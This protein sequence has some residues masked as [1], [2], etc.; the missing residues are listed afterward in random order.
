MEETKVFTKTLNIAGAVILCAA[1]GIASGNG[2]MPSKFMIRVENTTKPDAFTASNGLKWSLAFS[3][4]VAVIHTDKAPIF[5]SGKKDRGK[6]LEAQSEDGDPS[7]LAKSLEG[8]Q[9]I[10]SVVVFNTPAGASAPGP[11]TP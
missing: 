1:T 4:G 3:P 9:G 6:G 11:I 2:D 10:K 8:S 5:T 7:I